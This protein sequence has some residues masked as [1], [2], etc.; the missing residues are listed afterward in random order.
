VRLRRVGRDFLS[1]FS[2][3]VCRLRIDSNQRQRAGA[4]WQQR[5]GF[6]GS[7]PNGLDGSGWEVLEAGR[8]QRR[9]EEAW[10]VSWR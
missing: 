8:E 10:S 2:M 7:G 1:I 6:E 5:I 9:K 3:P 4:L